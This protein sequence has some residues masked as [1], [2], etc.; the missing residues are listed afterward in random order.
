MTHPFDAFLS[1]S[2]AADGKLA[3]A[4]QHAIQVFAKPL[5][6]RRVLRLFRD[7]TILSASPELWPNIERA[8]DNSRYFILLASPGAAQSKWVQREVE[9]WRAHRTPETLLIALTQG[10]LVWKESTND[11]DWEKTDALPPALTGVF[12]T[13]PLWVDLRWVT[14]ESMFSAKAP[15]F[16]DAVAS[17]A[18]PLRNCPKD[19]LIGEDVRQHRKVQWFTRGAVAALA[20]LAVALAAATFVAQKQ[21]DAAINQQQIATSR[22]LSAQATTRLS[23]RLDLA[24]LLAHQS[25]MTRSTLEAQSSLLSALQFSPYL[26]SFLHGPLTVIDSVTFSPDGTLL[27]GGGTDGSVYFWDVATR[28]PLGSALTTGQRTTNAASL[29]EDARNAVVFSPDG[30]LLASAGADD[31]LRLWNASTR[32]L[33]ASPLTGHTSIIG[34]LTFSHHGRL[35]ASGSWDRTIRLWDVRTAQLSG[36]PLEGAAMPITGLT[37]SPDDR[38]LAVASIDGAVVIWNIMTRKLVGMVI[39]PKSIGMGTTNSVAFSPHGELLIT[40]DDSGNIRVWDVTNKREHQKSPLSGHNGAV[41][42]IAFNAD[43]TRLLSAG[44]DHTIRQWDMQD[45]RALGEPMAG[46]NGVVKSAAFSP[47]G[48]TIAS[49]S[50]DGSVRLWGTAQNPPLST[51]FTGHTSLVEATVHSPDGKL[52]ASGGHDQSIRLWDAANGSLVATLTGHTKAVNALRFRVQDGLLA[53]GSEDGTVLF[54]DI[55]THKQVG[56]L[57]TGH[58]NGVKSLDFSPDGKMLATGGRDKSI[59]R[60][61]GLNI[62]FRI[63]GTARLWDVATRTAIGEPLQGHTSNVNAVAFSRDGRLLASGSSDSTARLWDVASQQAV[64]E[65]LIGH[66]GSVHCVSFS[67]DGKLLATGSKDKTIRFWDVA[68]RTAIGAPLAGHTNTV[69]SVAF[70]PDGTLLASAGS[71]GTLRLWD[72]AHREPFASPVHGGSHSVDFSPNGQWLVSGANNSVRIWDIRVESW[73]AEICRRVNRDL[74]HNEWTQFVGDAPYEKTCQ[75]HQ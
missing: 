15:Q 48:L 68:Q 4:L 52:I 40:T 30:K 54:W 50:A 2:H 51:T 70:S 13:E 6:K 10:T 36:A 8:L 56:K 72:I 69:D 28:Q 11:F 12:A 61:D 37:F 25:Y 60:A 55:S 39:E 1:Y 58:I 73:L 23:T 7:Q 53:S 18:S 5:F 46:H 47:D 3:P 21:R 57:D 43:G 67:P 62:N 45:M 20:T 38:L 41:L 26:K 17:L 35:L 9:W 27:A 65:P 31:A 75:Q 32:T 22:Q 14:S 44:W 34:A 16:Q 33:V 66:G 59:E 71:D 29:E 42:G 63:L 49:A 19:D 74:T 64:G 24:L